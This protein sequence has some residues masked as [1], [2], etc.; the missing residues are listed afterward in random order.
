MT[1]AAALGPGSIGS[2]ATATEEP[3][4]TV[5][6]QY[7]GV[8]GELAVMLRL[9]CET[10]RGNRRPCEP[11]KDSCRTMA[12]VISRDLGWNTLPATQTSASSR[13]PGRVIR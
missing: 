4:Y 12:F 6:Q 11:L 2:V 5:I 7:E 8:G 10:D 9:A 13:W 3:R 1:V